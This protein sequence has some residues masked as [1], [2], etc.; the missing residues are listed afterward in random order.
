M[1]ELSIAQSLVELIEDELIA[2]SAPGGA[3]DAG[4]QG[5]APR[6]RVGRV[7]VRVGP[8]SGVV[9]AAL[10]SAFPV[11]AG[12]SAA[13]RGATLA[14]DEAPLVG[15]CPACAADVVVPSPQRLRCPTC[16]GPTPDVVGGRELELVSIE[17][18]DPEEPSP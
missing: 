6:P 14:I 9:P 4:G 12:R 11:A 13:A 5:G 18:F 8:L 10:A 15:R 1:H 17:V 16:G 3:G 7:V 2:Q